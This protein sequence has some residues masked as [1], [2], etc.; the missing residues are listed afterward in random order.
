MR[1]VAVFFDNL[2][3]DVL[4]SELATTASRTA[5]VANKRKE[6]AQKRRRLFLFTTTSGRSK[7]GKSILEGR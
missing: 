5:V 7:G 6:R 2:L 4:V 1:E 3:L